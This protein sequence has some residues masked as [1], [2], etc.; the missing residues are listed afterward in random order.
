MQTA[1]DRG[2]LVNDVKVRLDQASYVVL[3]ITL[4]AGM[5]EM[6]ISLRKDRW[7]SQRLVK[8]QPKQ[9]TIKFD[10]DGLLSVR[11]AEG[12]DRYTPV[13]TSNTSRW[14]QRTEA[15]GLVDVREIELDELQSESEAAF[16]LEA[17]F[18]LRR[19]Y[20]RKKK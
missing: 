12:Q 10:R 5:Q 4:L 18:E 8:A 13:L 1:K 6:T 16:G 2:P 20:V 7:Q 15:D 3:P 19:K 9:F 17:N 14:V 11:G